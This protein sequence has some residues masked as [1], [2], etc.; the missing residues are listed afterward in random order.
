M[1][2][3]YIKPEVDLIDLSSKEELMLDLLNDLDPLL[4]GDIDHTS[5]PSWWD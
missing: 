4:E 5:K 3:V 1:K 2:K